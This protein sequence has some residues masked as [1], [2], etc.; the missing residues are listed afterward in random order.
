MVGRFG[1]AI[2]KNRENKR[3][4]TFS[5]RA[6]LL[7]AGQFGLLTA[8]VGRMYYLQVVESERYRMLAEENRIN[9]RLRAPSRG[10]V[11]DRFGVP[12]AVN[13]Q[14][15]RVLLKA[16]NAP[17]VSAILDRLSLIIPISAEEKARVLKDIR[18]RRKF[19]PVTVREFLDWEDVAQLEVNTPDLPG[20]E[21]DVGERRVY[22]NGEVGAHILGYVGVPLPKDLT[23]DPVLELPGF[24]VGRSGVERAFD[25]P[26][27]G[28]A[29]TSQLEVNAV[30]RVIRELDRQDGDPGQ[31]VVLTVDMALQR[32]AMKR[33]G[34]EAGS[35][36]LMDIETG[37]I[38][39]Q[40]STPSF[41][42]N[43]FTEDLSPAK[44]R[45]M[46]DNERAP[47]RNKAVAGEYAPGSTF[48]M[49]VALAALEAGVV[50]PKTTYVCPGFLEVGDG[51]FHCWRR[52]GHGVVELNRGIAESCDVYFYELAR[53]VGIDKI[54]KMAERFGLG[55]ELNLDTSGE[56]TGLVPSKAWKRA[57]IGQ[58]WMLG[59]TLI[60]G[61]GQGFITAT[62]MQLATMTARMVNGGKIVQPHVARDLVVR[63]K[64]TVRV[65]GEPE[66]I[67]VNSR[68]LKAIMDAMTLVMADPAG[69]AHRARI[70]APGMTMGGKTG[71]AQVRRITQ[72]ERDEGVI[73]NRDLPW[74]FRDHALFVG[75]GPVE[76]PRYAISVVVEHGGGGSA[77]AAPIA[78]DVM[79]AALKRDPARLAPGANVAG[80]RASD[81]RGQ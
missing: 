67:G 17:D 36:V 56:R 60:A 50:T 5:R 54:A 44:W 66:Y 38:I 27:R 26:L 30:G 47:L 74:R 78:R 15:Y 2:V 22:P 69:T 68:N 23:G 45:S 71:T 31:D 62:P 12:I 4:R 14:N 72:R 63:D 65:I 55:N 75:Y 11:L 34:D 18:S 13:H 1:A 57:V 70:K 35:V 42:P 59:E 10:R 64:L 33:L 40:A 39:V 61:I 48:K 43:A 24:K 19:V 53:R 77:V 20:I 16:E 58:P 28:R 37:G 8:L 32:E 49:I 52:K 51:K 7:A 9:I 3:Q 29:G 46:A 80:L 81:K 41:D 76:K 79:A 73:K 25:L 21:I 6:A